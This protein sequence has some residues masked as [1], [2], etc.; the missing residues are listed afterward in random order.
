MSRQVFLAMLIVPVFVT[1]S[2]AGTVVIGDFEGGLDGFT[3]A[4]ETT[5]T[6]NESTTGATTGSGA[7]E[8]NPEDTYTGGWSWAFQSNSTAVFAAAAAG[9]NPRLVADV[10]VIPSEWGSDGGDW[11]IWLQLSKV[12]IQGTD[13]DWTEFAVDDGGLSLYGQQAIDGIHQKTMTWDLSGFDWSTL[14]EAPSWTQIIFSTNF[15]TNGGAFTAIGNFYLDNIRIETD[16]P[17]SE[18]HRFECEDAV[19]EGTY[20]IYEDADCSGGQ[21]VQLE[22][23]PPDY[24]TDHGQITITVK[25]RQPG[26]YAM[27]IG[28]SSAGDLERYARLTI[29]DITTNIFSG[30][31]SWGAEAAIE[32]INSW[33]DQGVIQDLFDSVVLYGD[34]D[35]D[36]QLWDR[37]AT[38]Y[39]TVLLNTPMTVDLVEGENT[40][41]IFGEWA[42]DRWDFIELKLGY[43]PTEPSP[44][45]GGIGLIVENET[46]LS[47]KNATADL[48]K[49]EVWFGE[50]PVYVEGEPNSVVTSENYKDILS[51][52]ASIDSPGATSSLTLAGLGEGEDYTWVVDGFRGVT[53]GGDPNFVGPFWTFMATE[54]SKPTVVAGDDQFVWLDP[55]SVTVTLDGSASTD[56][57]LFNDPPAYTWTQLAG[58]TVTIDSPQDVSTTVTLTELGNNNEAGSGDPYVFQLAIDDGLW[59]ETDTVTVY[60]SSDSCLASHEMP[61]AFYAV[62]DFDQDCDVDL[63]DLSQMALNWLTC[64]NTLEDCN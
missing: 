57:G 62:G 52:I 60:V 15:G 20:F 29:N 51:L 13:L 18:W 45:D 61:G 1:L 9:L 63:V 4:W 21:Y 31:I 8:V 38:E 26:T 22:K 28:Q 59:V 44:Q 12:A 24:N 33:D 30:L 10:T 54:N 11:D 27:R 32:G 34:E 49:V 25:V 50:T 56:D 47:W 55:D 6:L 23:A 48:D 43:I 2:Y 39:D 46:T 16:E 64:T 35:G 19:L 37:W 40:I 17:V 5:V 58:P 3:L 41:N 7:M 36:W 53:E 42:W 14:P